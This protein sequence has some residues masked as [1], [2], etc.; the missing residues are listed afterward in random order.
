MI[1][2]SCKI[3]TTD[4]ILNGEKLD[5]FLLKSETRQGHLSLP[6]LVNIIIEVIVDSERQDLESG[7]GESTCRLGR[8]K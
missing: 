8:K 7:D 6:F 5:A 3:S 2:N 1:K 4:I